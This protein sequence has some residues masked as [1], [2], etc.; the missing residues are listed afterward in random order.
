MQ[1]GSSAENS[2][3]RGSFEAVT[4][5]AHA[6]ALSHSTAQ[7][8][9][10]VT[11]PLLARLLR[12]CLRGR[13]RGTTRLTYALARKVK[14]LQQ[15]PI[16]IPGWSPVY[17]DLR[18]GLAHLMLRDAPYSG[19]WREL[20]EVSI[21]R[22]FVLSGEVAFDIGANMGLHTVLLSHLVGTGGRLFAFE[23]NPEQLTALGR[24]VKELGNAE[25]HPVA[26]SDRNSE[27]ELFVPPDD[28]MASLANWIPWSANKDDGEPHTVSCH[29]RRLDDLIAE[30]VLPQP[31]FIKCDV[32]GAELL[33]F[34][35]GRTALDRADAPLI[36][37]EV[38]K[39]AARGFGFGVSD[40][41][42]FLAGLDSPR[43]RFF[44]VQKGGSL[45]AL[46]GTVHDFA[47]LLAVPESKIDRYPE[48]IEAR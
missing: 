45:S 38:N 5:E 9:T 26:L 29:E 35:G 33:V 47:N 41:K 23:P 3:E 24:T 19:L 42:D 39:N 7:G 6:A 10:G 21:M 14:S 40:A 37:F 15:V 46:S 17:I 31:D 13:L 18:L 12:L 22:R 27:S 44:E 25:L 4:A 8:A 43:Y 2:S 16:A 48:L 30:G 20:D 36:L 32:E 34:R 1:N 28:S 11:L